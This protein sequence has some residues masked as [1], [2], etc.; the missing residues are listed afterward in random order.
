MT[1]C[2]LFFFSMAMSSCRQLIQPALAPP[3]PVSA[4]PALRGTHLLAPTLCFTVL[5]RSRSMTPSGQA[6]NI[7]GGISPPQ[8]SI[9][10]S[11]RNPA[12]LPL[13]LL[14]SHHLQLQWWPKQCPRKRWTET[15]TET[16]FYHFPCLEVEL[17][18]KYGVRFLFIPI[19]KKYV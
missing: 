9:S 10:L 11:Q 19:L 4:T 8:P 13:S 7:S 1:Q 6:V 15:L 16:Q 5:T 3:L 17:S 2:T 14:I 18:K 12:S